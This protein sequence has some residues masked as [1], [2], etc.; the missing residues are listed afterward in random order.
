MPY[1]RA[2]YYLLGLIGL[3]GLAFWPNYFSRLGDVPW[4]LHAHGI[5]ASLWLLL[6]ISQSW[7][8]HHGKRSLHRAAG[9][10]SF[11]LAPLFLAS[12]F[13]VLKSMAQQTYGGH[14]FYE[15]FGAGLGLL[16]LLAVLFFAGFYYGALR[17]RRRVQLHARYLLATVLLLATPIASRLFLFYVPGLQVRGPE[18]MHLFAIGVHLGNA[19]GLAIALGLFLP[20]PKHGRP[21]LL[22][23]LFLVLSSIAFQ[24]LAAASPWQALF[25]S[26]GQAPSLAM[27]AIGLLLGALALWLGLRGSAPGEGRGP[28]VGKRDPDLIVG[29]KK[30][31]EVSIF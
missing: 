29:I 14:A 12:G 20:A 5:T 24:W 4:A 15:V 18:D 19:I 25:R 2:H 26:I 30:Q 3:V 22:A 27:A 23:A 21:F 13:L 1:P 6:L 11:V 31:T 28:G 17:H 9:R 7:A 8:I 16:D 10:S